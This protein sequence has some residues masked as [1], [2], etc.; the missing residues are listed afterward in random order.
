MLKVLFLEDDVDQLL[1]YKKGFEFEG[2]EMIGVVNGK[3]AKERVSQERP[4]LFLVDILLENENGLDVLAELKE[5]K[6]LEDVPVL[7][8]TN[9][10]K[11]D[12][13]DR[14]SRLGAIDYFL[15]V[16]HEPEDI[17]K[18]VKWLAA[19]KNQQN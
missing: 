4:D 15:K 16:E 8:F 17:A 11:K 10:E 2:I 12:F 7:I 3:E 1:V 19:S 18:K 9:Y 13:R 5:A 14:A 6:L